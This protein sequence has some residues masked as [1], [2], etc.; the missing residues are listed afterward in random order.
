MHAIETQFYTIHTDLA[1]LP[2]REASI[3]IT[4]MADE[5]E[6]RTRGFGGRID[7]KLPF[8][9]YQNPDDYYAAGGPKGTSGIFDGSRLMAVAGEKLTGLTWQTIQHEGFHQF[10]RTL[11]Q[12]DLPPWLNEG[13][14]EYFGEAI[15]TGDGYVVGVI[16]PWR[17][18]AHPQADPKR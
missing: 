7:Q 5:Y 17:A 13:L 1:D 10:A 4:K 15:F 6:R 8:Y 12:D 11:I 2:A 16:P 9:L 3:R 18:A 14:A